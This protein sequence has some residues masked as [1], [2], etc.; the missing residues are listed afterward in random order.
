MSRREVRLHHLVGR[1]V[2]DA[3]GCRIGRIQELLAE[4]E[5]HEHG[6]EY[7]VREFHIGAFGM[8]EAL[9]G[10]RFAQHAM[11]ALEWLTRYR[12]Y[13]VPWEL[14]D[15]SDPE[16]PRVTRSLRELARLSS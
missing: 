5:L 2:H 12:V 10:S 7:V 3:D 15:L 14:M 9:T 1:T 16:R 8:F 13:A 4:I 6:N 11:Q